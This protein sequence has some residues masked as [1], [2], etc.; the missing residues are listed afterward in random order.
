[1][2]TKPMLAGKFKD[3]E[4]ELQFPCE[5]TPKLDGIRALTINGKL[6]S[7]TFKNIQNKFIFDACASL[8]DG[9]D[10]ELIVG[11]TFSETTSAVMRQTG[12]PDF[13]YHVFDF[14]HGDLTRPYNLRMK[15]LKAIKLPDWCVL[16]LPET[17]DNIDELFMFEQVCL[18]VGFEGVMVRLA[19]SPYKCGRGTAKAHDLV[20]VK[21]FHD[22][23]AEILDFE[24][25]YANLNRAQKDAFGRTKRSTSKHNKHAKDTLGAIYVRAVNGDYQDV[26]FKIGT[27]FT[28][29]QR[30]DIWD[31]RNKLKGRL[32][33]F[34][35]QKE[36]G[37]DAPRFPVF[38]GFRNKEDM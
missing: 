20:K 23:E 27:G 13:K 1:M 21:R 30:E 38:L 15:D 37:K 4:K 2:I 12:K 3:L 24:P 29:D 16:V 19:K 5:A 31:R 28:H 6:V 32:V 8:P 10:G 35:Y 14:V 36:G 17:C 33:K 7:R 11:N 25:E 34:K 26:E 9:L 18:T 22:A